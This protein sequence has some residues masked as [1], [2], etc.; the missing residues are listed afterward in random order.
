MAVLA[1]AAAVLVCAAC[2][3]VSVQI[4]AALDA[5]LARQFDLDPQQTQ[6]QQQQV[7]GSHKM[8]AAS[9]AAEELDVCAGVGNLLD[10]STGV[11]LFKKVPRGTPCRVGQQQQQQGMSLTEWERRQQPQHRSIREVI[12]CFKLAAA[13]AATALQDAV[14]NSSGSSS[15]KRTKRRKRQQ[16]QQHKC[17]TPALAVD[18]AALLA[19]AMAVPGS[20]WGL[21]Q[22]KRHCAGG[23]S[24]SSSSQKQLAAAEGVVCD[25][26]PFV[27]HNLRMAVL[28]GQPQPAA[29]DSWSH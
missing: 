4:A 10:L 9:S 11:R 8:A 23:S 27:A 3:L 15:G 28:L 24:G 20:T 17:P 13:A 19:A 16:Q 5:M 22:D 1:A 2:K 6:Q 18:G 21:Q 25:G 7:G 26:R 12:P 29:A 14:A